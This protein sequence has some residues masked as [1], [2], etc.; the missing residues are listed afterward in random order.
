MTNPN[1]FSSDGGRN[2]IGH[3]TQ[4]NQ[5]ADATRSDGGR[6]TMTFTVPLPPKSSTYNLHLL[7]LY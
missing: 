1:V 2:P 7:S 4:P 3:R 5:T 6:S